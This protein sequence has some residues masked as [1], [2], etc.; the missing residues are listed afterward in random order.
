MQ[1]FRAGRDRQCLGT[2]EI[3]VRAIIVRRGAN[4]Q[5]P[6]RLTAPALQLCSCSQP[7]QQPSGRGSV[8]DGGVT[9]A[10]GP[11]AGSVHRLL[12]AVPAGGGQ[13]G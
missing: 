4:C 3:S 5:G 10:A 8:L 13:V 9:D 1:T 2:A 7:L 12:A 11:A 6:D